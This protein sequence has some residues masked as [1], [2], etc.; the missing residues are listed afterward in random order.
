MLRENAKLDEEYV[1]EYCKANDIEVYVKRAEVESIA[2][3]NK[4]GLEETGRNI[5]YEFFEEV[6]QKTGANK[7]AIAHNNNDNA[8]T[9]IMNLLRGSGISG[10]KGIEPIRNE[11]YIRPIIECT[12][13]EIEEYCSENNLAPRIDESNFENEYT[14]NK[15]RN[16][17][18]PYIQNE[19]N[20]NII[21]TINRLSETVREEECY[22]LGK[23]KEAY[24]QLVIYE[25][26][27]E[28]ALNLKS[29]IE[30]EK[31]IKRRIVLYTISKLQGN[32]LG[33]SKVH[34]EDI[35]EMCDKNIGNKYLT[36][37]K[38]LKVLVQNKKLYFV[39]K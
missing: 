8:E 29:F 4:A 26:E 12:R 37:N 39:A 18:I 28:I 7:I 10:L 17:C 36:P 2:K 11:K 32:S 19:F 22:I 13:N 9:V 30:L 5:R 31:V 16:I 23:T 34:V 3:E 15:I 38:N 21:N 35:I 14:R 20:P 24:E 1:E 27:G 25:K 6:M 33:V